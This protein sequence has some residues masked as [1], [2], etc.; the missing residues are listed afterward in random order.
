M[1]Q[2]A[3]DAGKSPVRVSLKGNSADIS[4][5]LK[6]VEPTGAQDIELRMGEQSWNFTLP[7]PGEFNIANAALACAMANSAGVEMN[8]FIAA[9]SDVAVPGRMERVN[10]GQDFIAVV[11]YAHKP[12]AVAAVL[13]TLS[14]QLDQAGTGGRIGIV[15]GAGGDRDST[16]RPLMGQAAAL[17]AD[18][19]VVTDD[20]PRTEDPA[21]I[22]AA[23]LQGARNAQSERNPTIVEE[24]SRAQAIDAVVSWARPGDAVIVGGKGHEVG[25]IVGTET[26]HFD[27]REELARALT[28]TGS[29]AAVDRGTENQ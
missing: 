17:R 23:V 28:S 7:L 12:A 4:A 18:Y 21:P 16:K 20:N 3:V 11:D 6:E 25:Q 9:I 8:S 26:L 27:D 2:A 1:A 13:D 24:P 10:R 22:R 5:R 29:A 14:E 19:V 15:V